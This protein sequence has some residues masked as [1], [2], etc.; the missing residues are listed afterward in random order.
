MLEVDFHGLVA[1][2]QRELL[3]KLKLSF[4]RISENRIRAMLHLFVNNLPEN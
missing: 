4:E 2:C 3:N 1:G